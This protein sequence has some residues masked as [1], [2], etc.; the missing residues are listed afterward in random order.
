MRIVHYYSRLL[1]HQSGVTMSLAAWAR[2]QQERAHEVT[3]LSAPAGPEQ[4]ED[5]EGLDVRAIEHFGRSRPTCLPRDFGRSLRDVDLLVLH[6]GWVFSNAAAALAARRADVPYVVIPHGV[7]EPGVMRGLKA[8]KPLR[9]RM[10]R[11]ILEGSVGVHVFFP[12]EAELISRIAPHADCFAVPTGAARAV[13]GWTGGGGYVAWFGRYAPEHKGLTRL[14]DAWA[15]I[16]VSRRPKLRM[17]GTDYYGGLAEVRTQVDDLG[18][19][20]QV[21]VG[22]PVY[23]EE[24][25]ELLRRAEA[26][27]HPSQWESH[28]V[29]LVEALERGVPSIVS[30]S[31]HIAASLADASAALVTPITPGG[32]ELA[33]RRLQTEQVLLS[34]RALEFVRCSLGWDTSVKA[35]DEALKARL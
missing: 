35:W 33:L 6:E 22:G 10:E 23:G 8:R 21:S 29:A 17:H 2:A 34:A 13:G 27:V 14:L 25:E 16:D 24:K 3:L 32:V 5:L 4:K 15:A 12:S 7:Y 1:R 9:Q 26:Y 28:S 11:A 19:G 30:D 18:L 20:D 31:I